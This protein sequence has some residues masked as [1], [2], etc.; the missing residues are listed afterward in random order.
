MGKD[1]IRFEKEFR[2]QMK[3]L[4]RQYLPTIGYKNIFVQKGYEADDIIASICFNLSM[5]D[6]AIIISSDQDLYQLIN[7]Q[8][9]SYNPVKKKILTLQGF[10]EKY[11]ILPHEWKLVKALAGCNTDGVP[12]VKGIGEKTAIKY[13]T[14]NLKATARAYQSITSK[15]GLRI[16]E[17]NMRLV[18]LPF[19]VTKVFKLQE[20]EITQ[21]GWNKV[22]KKLGMKSLR[23]KA[24]IFKR[25]G[26]KKNN[27]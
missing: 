10:K 15:E 26:K 13:L 9:S 14:K 11:G 22:M 2:W 21:E 20:D 17:R 24:P 12:G 27:E 23:D 6:K 7:F 18:S 16:F 25:K 1:T 4:R 5:L 19:K 8:V 3:M